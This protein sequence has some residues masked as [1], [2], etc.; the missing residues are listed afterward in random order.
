MN[1]LSIRFIQG[2]DRTLPVSAIVSGSSVLRRTAT[3]IASR[4]PLSQEDC[5]P[6]GP[7]ASSV[8]GIRFFP[9]AAVLVGFV[10][11]GE[12]AHLS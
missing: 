3:M 2:N 8:V 7:V 12:T 11:R 6:S 4:L 10:P 9:L 1:P 5:V